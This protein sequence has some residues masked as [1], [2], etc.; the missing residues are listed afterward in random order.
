MQIT[1]TVVRAPSHNTAHEVGSNAK[2]ILAGVDGVSA[3]RIERHEIDRATL[4]YEWTDPGT[5]RISID[6]TLKV[7]GM[8]RVR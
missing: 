7:G 4:S 1:I 3:V 5:N 8:R 6:E 2:R